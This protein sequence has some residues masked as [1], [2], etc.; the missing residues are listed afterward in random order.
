MKAVIETKPWLKDNK[1]YYAFIIKNNKEYVGWALLIKNNK[2]AEI[3]IYIKNSHRKNG[4]ASYLLNK[5]KSFSKRYDINKLI[6]YSHTNINKKFFLKN[7]FKP[8]GSYKSL[9]VYDFQ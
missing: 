7:S 1:N 5:I 3:N 4:H 9:L 8:E 2:D 6:A